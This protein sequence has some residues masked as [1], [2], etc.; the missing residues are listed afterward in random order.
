MAH[1]RKERLS[2]DQFDEAVTTAFVVFI[3]IATIA[4]L[5]RVVS[6]LL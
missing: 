2:D 6:A 1:H 5:L 3:A 4:G